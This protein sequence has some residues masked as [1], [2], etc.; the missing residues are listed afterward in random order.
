MSLSP[1]QLCFNV[2][3]REMFVGDGTDTKKSYDGTAVPGVPGLGW[4]SVPLS[5]SE[6]DN[7]YVV[8]P[9]YYG[10]IPLDGEVLTW[11]STLNRVVWKDS[12][13]P[14]SYLTTNAAVDAAPGAD[15]TS[16]ISSALGITPTEGD[17][18]IVSGTSGDTYQ[19]FYQYV[20]GFWTYAA[21][22]APPLASE[23][24]IAPIPGL[25]ATNTQDAIEEVLGIADAAQTTASNALTVANNALPKSGGTMTGNIQ[26]ADG[27][28]VDAGPY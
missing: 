24:P 23:V 27:Q 8:N 28:P 2:A 20:G 15:I 26:F 18:A 10:Q 9:S 12:P 3:D 13:A 7:Y 17:S 21:S 14:T 25:T 19:A 5:F 4:F 22:Y 1:G 11:D 16:K 6:T